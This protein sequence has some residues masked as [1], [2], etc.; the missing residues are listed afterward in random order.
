VKILFIIYT[1]THLIKFLIGGVKTDRLTFSIQP[2]ATVL[3]ILMRTAEIIRWD[4]STN[5]KTTTTN[6]R[7][8]GTFV[9]IVT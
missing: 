6:P 5:A 3:Q 1:I 2:I 7:T 4:N 8:T 9:P